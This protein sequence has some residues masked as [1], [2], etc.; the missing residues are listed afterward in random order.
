MALF[1]VGAVVEEVLAVLG[2]DGVGAGDVV[3]AV[4]LALALAHALAGEIEELG[5]A[6]V[7][8]LL[9][10]RHH[11]ARLAGGL[12]GALAVELGK[13]GGVVRAALAFAAGE[14]ADEG[15]G[16]VSGVF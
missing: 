12:G 11:R 4:D 8:A 15:G 9:E 3:A 10:L 2:A 7:G 5:L 6:A 14:G 16:R 1:G 13:D